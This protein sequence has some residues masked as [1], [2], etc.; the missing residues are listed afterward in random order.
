VILAVVFLVML[1]ACSRSSVQDESETTAADATTAPTTSTTHA[2]AATTTAGQSVPTGGTTIDS[3]ITEPDGRDRTYRLYV[4]SSLPAGPAPLLIALHGGTGW[5]TQFE[6]NSGFDDI[7]DV[8]GF[9]VV[10][11][12]GIEIP[13][14]RG[15]VW[16]GGDC[17]GIAA[18]DRQDV[19]DLGFISDLIDVIETDYPIDET[20]VYATGHSNGAIMSYRLACEL[21]DRIVAVG[22]QAGSLEIDDCRP[23]RPVSVLH[24]HGSADTNIPLD[25]G[26]GSGISNTDFNSPRASVEKLAML[27]GCGPRVDSVDEENPDVAHRIW[28]PCDE[29]T[30]VEMVIV[31]GANHAWMGHKAT[32]VQEEIVGSPYMGYDSSAAIRDFLAA[33]PRR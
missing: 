16:N 32:R 20:R 25:G 1:T 30:T 6:T 3:S 28:E 8:N 5:G 23:D 2:D 4:P 19:D 7:A 15:G 21:S 31:E 29:G 26:H 14:L 13:L 12:D 33:H 27:D 17:C 11:P 18:Q 24:I 10:Y 9:I 22:F